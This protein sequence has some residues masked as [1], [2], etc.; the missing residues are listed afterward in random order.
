MDLLTELNRNGITIIIVTH[1]REVAAQTRR[2]IRLQDGL[3][4]ADDGAPSLLA[5]NY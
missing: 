3:V 1:D 2:M 5:P 4:I